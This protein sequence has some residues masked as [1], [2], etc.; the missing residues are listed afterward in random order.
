LLETAYHFSRQSHLSS[1]TTAVSVQDITSLPAL[2][3]TRTIIDWTNP[4]PVSVTIRP[5]SGQGL[6][7]NDKTY[8]MVG[9]VSD[10]GRSLCR[11]MVENGAKYIVLTSRRA[12]V[13]QLWLQEMEDLGA[14]VRVYPMDVSKRDSVQ[15]VCDSIK[16]LPPVGGVCNGALVLKDQLFVKM[17]PDALSDVFAPKVDGTIHLSDIFS[18]P[19]LDFF[20][21]FSSMSSVVGNAGQSNYNAASLFQAAIAQQRRE[22]G[23]AASVMALGMV[24]DVGYIAAKGPTLMERLKKAFYMPISESDAHQ[25][26]AEAVAASKPGVTDDDTIEM[27]SGIQ[28]FNYTASTKARPP[29]VNNPRFSHFVRE[30]EGSKDVD[31]SRAGQSNI[32]ILERLDAAGSEEEAAAALL[33]AFR[34]KVET[35]LQMTPDSLNVEASLLDVGI[36]SLLA[37]EIRSWFL[38]EVHV[39][40]PVLKTL[41][42]DNAKDI[43]ADAAN[44]YLSAKMQENKSETGDAS[45]SDSA[46][47]GS[48]TGTSSD[49]SSSPVRSGHATPPS[50]VGETEQQEEVKQE[51][52]LE[53]VEKLSYAQSR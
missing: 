13:D 17:E 47:N 50:T 11:W 9:L 35:M 31:A 23:L 30:E 14:I 2:D 1:P 18:E 51:K 7:S 43:C 29:W 37:V 52:E 22:K 49:G 5:I 27:V 42:G 20:V 6:F 48:A 10:F 40:V 46:A 33:V 19:T 25:I 39:D 26:F 38:K 53:R 28:P 41:S 32:R 3:L 24:A 45:K 4:Q 21:L 8:L 15:S 16:N 36:D 34:A 12:Q 44:K